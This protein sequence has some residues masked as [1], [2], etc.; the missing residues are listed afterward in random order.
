MIKASRSCGVYH[1]ISKRTVLAMTTPSILD[2]VDEN[3][4][5]ITSF[6]PDTG[7]V[8]IDLQNAATLMHLTFTLPSLK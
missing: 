1:N 3:A 5:S 7:V 8:C 4:W 6:D 2:E